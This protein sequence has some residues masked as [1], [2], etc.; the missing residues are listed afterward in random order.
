MSYQFNKSIG[1]VYYD[2]FALY[3]RLPLTLRP[4]KAMFCNISI[5]CQSNANNFLCGILFFC[6]LQPFMRFKGHE[7]ILSQFKKLY[8]IPLSFS[9]TPFSLHMTYFNHIII[10]AFLKNNCFEESFMIK[11]TCDDVLNMYVHYKW[12]LNRIW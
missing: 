4:K 10:R 8:T 7:L 3:Y 6:D 2:L 5:P 11:E 9:C 12:L 1:I